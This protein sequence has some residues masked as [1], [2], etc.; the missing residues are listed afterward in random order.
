MTSS[1]GIGQL[2][3]GLGHP[4][5][6]AFRKTIETGKP[7]GR[8]KF[9][10]VEDLADLAPIV[11]GTFVHTPGNRLLFFPGGSTKITTDDPHDQFSGKR[12]DHITL[13]PSVKP[14]RH[15]SHVA[16][17]GLTHEKSRGLNYTTRPP[18]G[19]GVPWF[20]LLVPDLR[21]YHQLPKQL[22]IHFPRS[23]PDGSRFGEQLLS[24]GGLGFVPLPSHPGSPSYIQFDIWA[25]RGAGWERLGDKP[26]SWPYKPELVANAPRGLQAVQVN[27]LSMGFSP[28]LGIVV[29]VC[30][31]IGQLRGSKSLRP[32]IADP[33]NDV[34]SSG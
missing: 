20:S 30:R 3:V 27:R 7:P 22:K 19:Y 34:S 9:F 11:V 31:P 2:E 21:G 28:T 6:G 29:N 12:L 13:D 5:A 18:A 25:G 32:N 23:R 1:A 33:D 26:L 14:G 15:A 16:V 4:L 24:N 17:L 10:L 8:W